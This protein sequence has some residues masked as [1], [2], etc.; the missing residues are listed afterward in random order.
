MAVAAAR[1]CRLAA[2]TGR[3]LAMISESGLGLPTRLLP[4]AP[5]RVVVTIIAPLIMGFDPNRVLL[6][7]GVGTL[8]I[9]RLSS[10]TR[11]CARARASLQKTGNSVR[12]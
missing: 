5:A 11:A 3:V 12:E 9:G 10:E 6:F 7:S 4:R 2:V 1:S 8:T